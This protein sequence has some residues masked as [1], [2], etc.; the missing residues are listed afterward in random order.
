[1]YFK[2][3]WDCPETHKEKSVGITA[4]NI[5]EAIHQNFHPDET[6]RFV[7]FYDS[8]QQ[9]SNYEAGLIQDKMLVNEQ[10][11]WRR[12]CVLMTEAFFQPTLRSVH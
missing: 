11:M 9:C 1:M 10:A 12:T 4:D 7:E 8:E 2:I 5:V 6:L 3:F